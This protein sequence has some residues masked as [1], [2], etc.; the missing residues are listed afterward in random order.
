MTASTPTHAKT[1]LWAPRRQLT[2]AEARKRSNLV[3]ALRVVFMAG[4]A[5]SIGFFA[6]HIIQN[7]VQQEAS[8]VTLDDNDVVTMVNPR[9]SGRDSTGAAYVITADNARQRRALNGVVDLIGPVLKDEVGTE[10]RAPSGMYDREAGILELYDD[11]VITDPTGYSFK[12]A[13]ARVF[14]AEGRV[15]GLSPLEGKGPLGDIRSDS[16]EILDDGNRAIFTGNVRTVIYPSEKETDTD[17]ET[18]GED[19]TSSG[20]AAGGSAGDEASNGESNDN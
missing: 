3:R 11:V 17:T 14:V 10:V 4:A 20:D 15:E 1:V 7:A 18:G 6:G 8:S 19:D 12:T 16:Y 2:L 9:F 13:G 5:I